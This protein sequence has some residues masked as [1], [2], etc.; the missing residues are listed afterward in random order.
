MS[1]NA[2]GQLAQL[3]TPG[4]TAG[5][6]G[7]HAGNWYHGADNTGTDQGHRGN[8]SQFPGTPLTPDVAG[9]AAARGFLFPTTPAVNTTT[10]ATTP[11]PMA[12]GSALQAAINKVIDKQTVKD[13]KHEFNW[14]CASGA[15][16][17]N[18][19]REELLATETIQAFGIVK[20]GSTTVT[21]VHGLR[22]YYNGN[23]APEL[24]GKVLGRIGDWT[25]DAAR[26]LYV[27][28]LKYLLESLCK[29]NAN[30][31]QTT[32]PIIINS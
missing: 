20:S 2:T 27:S 11:Q 14:Q 7:I 8:P 16:R 30:G 19:F 10:A 17:V 22:K 26:I 15:T 4:A 1:E 3:V 28:R 18:E 12:V 25:A 21:I 29:S 23:V 9:G 5:D 31:H 6:L 32:T 24:R 13:K